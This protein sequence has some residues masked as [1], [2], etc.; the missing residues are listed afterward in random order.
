MKL[1]LLEDGKKKG[2]ADIQQQQKQRVLYL[3]LISLPSQGE[4]R[5]KG[6]IEYSWRVARK[7]LCR[8][9]M[10][11][12]LVPDIPTDGWPGKGPGPLGIL[13][14]AKPALFGCANTEKKIMVV[15]LLP[16]FRESDLPLGQKKRPAGKAA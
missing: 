3:Y 10:N 12:I 16:V 7:E 5:A 4:V 6:V 8:G 1:A 14:A 11:Q 13:I 9:I 15:N 2:D